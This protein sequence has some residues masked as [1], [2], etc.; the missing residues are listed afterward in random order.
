MIFPGRY[1]PNQSICIRNR[2]RSCGMQNPLACG[3]LADTQRPLSQTWVNNRFGKVCYSR[4]TTH[5]EEFTRTM[6]P[7]THFVNRVDGWK[8]KA[9]SKPKKF[10]K[11][12]NFGTK[13]FVPCFF[14]KITLAGLPVNTLE[15]CRE[16]QEI[17]VW[18][19]SLI[20]F[21]YKS[22]PQIFSRQLRKNRKM[23]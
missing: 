23:R 14:R 9:T 17:S 8:L 3:L 11:E 16:K 10:L 15:V 18:I 21:G 20:K 2:S 1:L 4:M 12:S 7:S 13:F 22:V 6:T 5:P 19:H